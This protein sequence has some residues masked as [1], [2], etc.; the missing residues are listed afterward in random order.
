MLFRKQIS[1]SCQHCAYSARLDENQMLCT[2][3]GVVSMY[4][5]CRKFKYDPCKRIPPKPRAI[6]FEKYQDEDFSL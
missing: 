6:D 2:K 1:R 3:R 4:Y 5:E